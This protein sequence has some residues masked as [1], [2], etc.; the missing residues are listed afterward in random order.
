[1]CLCKKELHVSHTHGSVYAYTPHV[2]AIY[3]FTYSFVGGSTP[4]VSYTEEDD[5]GSCYT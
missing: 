3:Y 1:M 5:S 2:V 4:I